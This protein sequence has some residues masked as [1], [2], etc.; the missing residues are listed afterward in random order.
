MQFYND[1]EVIVK[2]WLTHYSEFGVMLHDLDRDIKETRELLSTMRDITP[3][4]KY[5]GMPHGSDGQ[6]Y[7][8]E[9]VT[10]DIIETEAKLKNLK[11]SREILD[12][13]LGRLKR[14]MDTLPAED[15]EILESRFLYNVPFTRIGKSD[16]WSKRKV[17]RLIKQL[18]LYIFGIEA[19]TT[20]ENPYNFLI[21]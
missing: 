21:K 8:V 3:I 17:R 4:A 11:R 15:K 7:E 6:L 20:R 16:T 2:H 19:E 12:N 13:H 10:S 9:R 14:A 18:A 1:Y 5:E